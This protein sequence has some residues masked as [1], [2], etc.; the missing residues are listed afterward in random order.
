MAAA[1]GGGGQFFVLRHDSGVNMEWSKEEDAVLRDAVVR[2][3]SEPVSV[4]YA[5][6]SR[7]LQDKSARDVAFRIA[8]MTK[9]EREKRVKKDSGR[10]KGKNGN[11]DASAN[12]LAA[13]GGVHGQRLEKNMQFLDQISRNLSSNQFQGSIELMCVTLDNMLK[14]VN[15]TKD[16]PGMPPLPVRVNTELID[17]LVACRGTQGHKSSGFG[18]CL[19]SSKP[20][21][22]FLDA[23]RMDVDM[24]H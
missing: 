12:I 4:R 22:A 6:I 9:K 20:Q 7:L 19:G 13:V 8:W 18:T 5:T 1:D 23:E 10:L 15:D 17:E 14:I 16:I 3:A 21:G 11:A 24:L 2:Y